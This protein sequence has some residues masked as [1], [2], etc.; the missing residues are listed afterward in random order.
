MIRDT[1]E[2]TVKVEKGDLLA[3][4]K[5]NRQQHEQAFLTAYEGYTQTLIEELEGKL[6]QVKAGKTPKDRVYINAVRPENHTDDYDDAIDMLEMADDKVIEMTQSQFRQYARDDW[7]WKQ[8][9]TTSNSAYIAKA[10]G[11]GGIR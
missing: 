2:I 8:Q 1:G 4:L 7:G 11:A 9:W 6:A 5:D 10:T 3:R